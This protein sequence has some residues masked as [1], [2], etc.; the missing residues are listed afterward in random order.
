MKDKNP[1][2]LPMSMEKAA[3]C[4]MKARTAPA[5]S[6]AGA[7]LAPGPKPVGWKLN[8]TPSPKIGGVSK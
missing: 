1:S 2:L 3:S 8:G 6:Y 5:G 7:N 4:A